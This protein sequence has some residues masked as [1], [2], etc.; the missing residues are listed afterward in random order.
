MQSFVELIAKCSS[1]MGQIGSPVTSEQSPGRV[2][3]QRQQ[4]GRLPQPQLR[5]ILAHGGI[6]SIMQAILNSKVALAP[7]RAGDGDQRIR[8]ANW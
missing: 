5:M 4:V 2:V 1:G 3:E 8:L 7:R 6:A